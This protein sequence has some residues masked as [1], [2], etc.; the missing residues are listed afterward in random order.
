[1]R[2]GASR[3]P[4]PALGFMRRRTAPL[5]AAE[6]GLC[7]WIHP[8]ADSQPTSQQALVRTHHASHAP[9]SFGQLPLAACETADDFPTAV[10]P[11]GI[12]IIGATSGQ[13]G[14]VD[15]ARCLLG[16]E[17][18]ANRSCYLI[19]SLRSLEGG[20]MYGSIRNGGGESERCG[21]GQSSDG[22]FHFRILS[23]I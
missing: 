2:G 22:L 19:D 12:S 3:G 13:T 4:V 11:P 10:F 16:T 14:H 8:A 6:L 18:R 15:S 17:R 21:Y 20:R 1:M 23:V 9:G 5:V 7:L